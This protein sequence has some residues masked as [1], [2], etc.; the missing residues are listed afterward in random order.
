MSFVLDNSVAMCWLLNDG[1]ADDLAYAL[2]VLEALKQTFAT[3]PGLWALEAANVVAKVEAKGLTGREKDRNCFCW[4]FACII[5][6]AVLGLHPPR[7][8]RV[9]A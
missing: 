2:D 1:Q 6:A 8:S 4:N 9:S 5:M 7:R 3:V